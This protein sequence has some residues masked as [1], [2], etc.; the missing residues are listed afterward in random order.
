MQCGAPGAPRSLAVS[1]VGSSSF[2]SSIKC[3]DPRHTRFRP[4]RFSTPRGS[5][6]AFP[7][8]QGAQ[9]MLEAELALEEGASALAETEPAEE[10]AAGFTSPHVASPKRTTISWAV[11]YAKSDRCACFRTGQ[12]ISL[13]EM[14]VVKRTTS[15]EGFEM[16]YSIKVDAFF[17]LLSRMKQ[18]TEKPQAACALHGFEELA[19][20][21]QARMTEM[22]AKFHAGDQFFAHV[23]L[24]RRESLQLQK[25]HKRPKPEERRFTCSVPGCPKAYSSSTC[26]SRHHK[27]AHPELGNLSKRRRKYPLPTTKVEPWPDPPL[28]SQGSLS[29]VC[30][31]IDAGAMPIANCFVVSEESAA[32]DDSIR[33]E[34]VP[35]VP[36]VAEVDEVPAAHPLPPNAAERRFVC[37][38]VGCNKAYTTSHC[39]YI[40]KRNHHPELVRPKA[41]RVACAAPQ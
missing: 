11:D 17:H 20:D 2:L 26:L 36:E 13:G 4:G 14:R 28:S 38:A 5:R 9:I 35:H 15:A 10:R 12:A 19:K 6:G 29:Q 1:A 34:A 37:P 8:T 24:P 31:P 23:N 18:T 16:A 30:M 7:P 32:L 27:Q 40:H 33:V 39:L 22:F 21:D 25:K 41:K 3:V